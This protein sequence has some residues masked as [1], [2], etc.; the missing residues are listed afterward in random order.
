[1]HCWRWFCAYEYSGVSILERLRPGYQNIV[2]N[3]S[4]LGIVSQFQLITWGVD[5][6]TGDFRPQDFRSIANGF[7][8]NSNKLSEKEDIRA[9]IEWIW[10]QKGPALLDVMI[11]PSA[12]VRPMLLAGQTMDDMWKG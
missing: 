6:T 12:D 4:R 2:F 9:K 5:P 7:G 8:I 10:E 3:N 11:D 1:M